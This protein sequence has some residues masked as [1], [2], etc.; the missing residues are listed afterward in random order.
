LMQGFLLAP[1]LPLSQAQYFPL[2]RDCS[3]LPYHN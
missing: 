3:C 2:Q 1:G